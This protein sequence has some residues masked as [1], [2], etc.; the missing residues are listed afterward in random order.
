ME[1]RCSGNVRSG[2]DRIGDAF[3]ERVE[4][5]RGELLRRGLV[6]DRHERELLARSPEARNRA[7]R[8]THAD[9]PLRRRRDS[10]LQD[11]DRRLTDAPV[12]TSKSGGWS[13]RPARG[14]S[15][16]SPKTANGHS[17]VPKSLPA[18]PNFGRRERRSSRPRERPVRIGSPAA[19]WRSAR[20][21]R[22]GRK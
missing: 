14:S 21:D 7:T 2:G 11:G 6:A 8:R 13:G 12:I 20:A 15:A 19:A 1:P 3:A 17:G 4:E 16:R 9:D 10:R 5:R 18:R 22:K